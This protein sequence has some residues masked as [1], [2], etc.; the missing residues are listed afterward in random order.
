MVY[1]YAT[2]LTGN[3]A[4][5]AQMEEATKLNQVV[6][7]CN[8]ITGWAKYFPSGGRF[9]TFYM[10]ILFKYDCVCIYLFLK[11]STP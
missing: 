8:V 6:M 3:G 2:Y 5:T 11:A 10:I 1:I 4:K 7:I 9:L